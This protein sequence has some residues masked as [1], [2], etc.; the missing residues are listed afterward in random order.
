MWDKTLASHGSL[1]IASCLLN[2]RK[3]L[4]D[5][6]RHLNAYS[7]FCGGQNRNE[8]IALTWMHIVLSNDFNLDTIDH[9]SLEPGNTY[10]ACDR[11]FG[12]IE[13]KKKITPNVW[14]PSEW[15]ALVKDS[16]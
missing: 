6:I 5:N 8:N 12:V 3:Q 7:D 16:N 15:H 11:D 13:K 4:P 10:N 14:T 9:K 1:E 2:Y